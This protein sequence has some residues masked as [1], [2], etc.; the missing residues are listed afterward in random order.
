MDAQVH[1][2]D[3]TRR[4]QCG[5]MAQSREE[6]L[7]VVREAAVELFDIDADLIVESARF[8]EDLET[9]SL[10]LVE[11]LMVLEERLGISV[12]EESFQGVS[13]VG[14]AIEV[15]LDLIKTA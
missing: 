7:G 9:D 8:T 11:L 12:P 14:Q 3:E 15:L 13:T 5:P 6:V 10:D 2:A 1:I 4:L